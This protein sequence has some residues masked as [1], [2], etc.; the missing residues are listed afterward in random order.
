M[1]KIIILLIVGLVA[2]DG[3]VRFKSHGAAISKEQQE[4]PIK[5]SLKQGKV[6]GGKKYPALVRY[7]RRMG[8]RGE[9]SLIRSAIDV[10]VE[11]IARK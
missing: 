11:L 3:Y 4:N 7:H 5:I 8:H 1:R 6:H 10:M 9:K 2:W